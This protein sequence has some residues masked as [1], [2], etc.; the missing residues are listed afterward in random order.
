MHLLSSSHSSGAHLPVA[1]QALTQ[2]HQLARNPPLISV[3][4]QV[5]DVPGEVAIQ[6]A[7]RHLQRHVHVGARVA[8]LEDPQ[9]VLEW[10]NHVW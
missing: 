4:E 2:L 9:V 5:A 7:A 6:P 1:R 8:G 10:A 3:L